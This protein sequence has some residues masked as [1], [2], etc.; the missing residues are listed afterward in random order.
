[1]AENKTQLNDASVEAFLHAVEPEQ[2][3]ND[4]LAILQLMQEVTG[5]VPKMWGTSIV[6]FGTYHYKYESGREGDSL[7]VGFSPRKQNLTLYIMP[8]FKHYEDLLSR[9]GK[10]STGKACLYVNKLKEIN[11]DVL[12]ELV[13]KSVDHM[14]ATHQL[15]CLRHQ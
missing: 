12:R 4:A 7:I 14:K 13:A 2:K 10:H 11:L 5:E 15:P 1:M 9:L 3:R 8:G 6:G